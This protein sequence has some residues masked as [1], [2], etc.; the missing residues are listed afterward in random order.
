MIPQLLYRGDGD[1]QNERS[2]RIV[3]PGSAYGGL[4]TNLS[5]GGSGRDIF[6][7]PFI[8][9]VNHH[10]DEG[11]AK[12][13]Y[14]SFSEYRARAMT[15]ASGKSGKN[16]KPVERGGSWDAALITLDTGRFT[17]CEELEIGV[18]RCLYPR[19]PISASQLSI[20]ELIM[21]SFDNAKLVGQPVEILLIDVASFLC[22]QV[23][24]TKEDLSTAIA[25]AKRDAEWLVL[26]TGYAVE[27]PGEFTSKL[28]DGCI[29]GFECFR[30]L[31]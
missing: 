12:T 30:F 22:A 21:R 10:V 18:Y 31:S 2:L 5:N 4:L 24:K 27:I 7:S 23:E 16:L 9:T 3:Y 15:F 14:L 25:N 11:W 13:H 28:D 17:K 26:P 19:K 1:A 6:S 20:P 29:L 8:S